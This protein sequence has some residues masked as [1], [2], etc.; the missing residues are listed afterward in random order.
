MIPLKNEKF[1]LPSSHCSGPKVQWWLCK[2]MIQD[3]KVRL[4]LVL[5]SWKLGVENKECQVVAEVFQCSHCDISTAPPHPLWTLP[6]GKHTKC[7][8][9]SREVHCQRCTRNEE[10]P[11]LTFFNI[12]FSFHFF[13]HLFCFGEA[14]FL[15]R[16]NPTS[17]CYWSVYTTTFLHHPPLFSMRLHYL[18]CGE[19]KF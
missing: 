9:E 19:N 5:E 10:K 11:T 7:Q 8:T 17:F 14:R 3:F 4:E 1:L 13:F 15:E 12:Y 18:F 2:F 16:I 6:S